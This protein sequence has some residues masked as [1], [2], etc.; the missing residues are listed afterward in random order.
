MTGSERDGL[1]VPVTAH[2]T[3]TSPLPSRSKKSTQ[4][5]NHHRNL[6][7]DLRVPPDVEGQMYYD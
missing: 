6:H 7:A 4:C 3:A 1:L 2:D 5:V